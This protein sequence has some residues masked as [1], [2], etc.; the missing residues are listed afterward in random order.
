MTWYYSVAKTA[1]ILGVDKSTVYRLLKCSALSAC[2]LHYASHQ[3]IAAVE[4]HAYMQY[5]CAFKDCTYKE[6]QAI[7][8][9]VAYEQQL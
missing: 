1:R 7:L 3:K 6:Q 9:L 4:V 2:Q 5:H 8:S